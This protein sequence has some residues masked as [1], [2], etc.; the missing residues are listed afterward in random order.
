MQRKR[1]EKKLHLFLSCN[2]FQKNLSHTISFLFTNISIILYLST[3]IIINNNTLINTF[4]IYVRKL[5]STFQERN[6]K[7]LKNN[8]LIL[9]WILHF[10]PSTILYGNFKVDATGYRENVL[11]KNVEIWPKL[12]QQFLSLILVV[13]LV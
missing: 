2:C 9:I 7:G 4:E 11:R 8:D 12:K 6:I 13:Y 10:L 1:L 3:Y 5:T